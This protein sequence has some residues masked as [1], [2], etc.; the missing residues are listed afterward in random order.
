MGNPL[1]VYET[2]YKVKKVKKIL[3]RK[4]WPLS[5]L[6]FLEWLSFVPSWTKKKNELNH[7][8]LL[9][10]WTISEKWRG[11]PICKSICIVIIHILEHLGNFK[12]SRIYKEFS[13]LSFEAD[14]FQI[15]IEIFLIKIG[16]L[17]THWKA[18]SE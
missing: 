17:T 14:F 6:L 13:S 15:F 3:L 12:S 1:G 10:F 16:W 18:F 7:L 9:I 2:N 8:I 4:V 5:D 11:G